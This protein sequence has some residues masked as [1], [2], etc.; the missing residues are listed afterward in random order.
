MRA[1][2]SLRIFELGELSLAVSQRISR[3]VFLIYNYCINYRPFW[4]KVI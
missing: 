1:F 4:A 3:M 2:L